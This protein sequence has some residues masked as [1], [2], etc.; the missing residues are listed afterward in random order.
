ML[1]KSF[2]TNKIFSNNPAKFCL[3]YGVNIGLVNLLGDK[4][5]KFFHEYEIIY[6][7]QD[8]IEN[9]FSRV[10]DILN[11]ISFLSDNKVIVINNV[12]DKI[13]KNIENLLKLYNGDNVV[14]LKSTT[15]NTKSKLVNLLSK[16]KDNNVIC[17]PCYGENDKGLLN[18]VQ[19]EVNAHNL[20]ISSA[21][22]KYIVSL[23]C[24]DTVIARNDVN[25]IC[26][27]CID[28][29][30][31]EKEDID[32]CM[33]SSKNY[34]P[35]DLVYKLLSGDI[36]FF[37]K[38]Y[39]RIIINT[40]D[41]MFFLTTLADTLQKLYLARVMQDNGIS[42]DNIVKDKSINI[43][44]THQFQF[45]GM[46]LRWNKVKILKAVTKYNELTS[47]MLVNDIGFDNNFIQKKC[48][49]ISLFSK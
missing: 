40:N 43:F 34:M 21:N 41:R 15:L 20:K 17:V 26:I 47:R 11:E 37:T 42:V 1:V 3:F 46:M 31:I 10:Y 24:D 38:N 14:V 35:N 6:F 48:I 7:E 5:K 8:E 27:F 19:D 22:C 32:M 30:T 39:E 9:D 45:K 13:F 36:K 49:E 18:I 23:I 16:S 25:K 29:G 33:E 28:K 2:E 12:T 4:Y 44:W